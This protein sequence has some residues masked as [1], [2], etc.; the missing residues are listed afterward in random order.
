MRVACACSRSAAR[1][2]GIAARSKRTRRTRLP[3]PRA[4]RATQR[5][6]CSLRAANWIRGADLPK[7]LRRLVSAGTCVSF[8]SRCCWRTSQ[9]S[10]TALTIGATCICPPLG[11]IGLTGSSAFD[12]ERCLDAIARYRPDSIILLPQMLRLLVAQLARAGTYDSRVRSLEYVTVGGAKTPVALIERAR[13]LGLPVYE[14]YGLTECASVVSLNVPG[15]DRLGT[16]G[17]PLA[18]VRVRVDFRWRARDW[19]PHVFGLCRLGARRIP[20]H[21]LRSGDLG[22]ID[23]DGFISIV[24]RKKNVIVT[25]Y[26]TQRIAGMAGKPAA[27]KS[28]PCAGSRLWRGVVLTLSRCSWP[29]LGRRRTPRSNPQSHAPTARLPDY[30]RVRKLD[31]RARTVHR[32]KTDSPPATGACVARRFKPVTTATSRVLS[33]EGAE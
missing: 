5:V 6:S 9:A 30:A 1:M 21:G 7:S 18:G 12:P 11:E 15:A 33:S 29:P 17:R 4:P 28:G 13:A 31:S 8:R 16:V 20:P 19:R 22:A 3:S 14:G 32:A 26:R 27:R 25:S 24:G 2:P 10:Y 23:T